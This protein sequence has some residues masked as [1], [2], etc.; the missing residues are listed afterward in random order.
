MKI[1]LKVPKY[2][3]KIQEKLLEN[4][5]ECYFVGGCIRDTLLGLKVND[6]DISTN[7]DTITLK[8]LFSKYNIVNNNGEKHNT[9]TLH[10]KGDNV[11]ITTFK[12]NDEE[13]PTIE[14]DLK[15]RDLTINALAYSNEIID[16]TG[17]ID[18]I[19][20]KIIRANA[21]ELRIKEDP[22]RIL[23]VLRFTSKLG[24]EIEK[25]TNDAILKYK[26]LLKNVSAERIKH[27]LEEILEGKDVY[28]ILEKYY[29]IIFVI[30]PELKCSYKFNQ[31][32][33]YHENTLYE[34]IINVC[35][36]IKIN[37][38]LEEFALLRMAALLH[39]IGKPNCFSID[40]NGVGHFYGHPEESAIIATNILKRLKFSNSEI[41]K[42][43]YLIK[44]HDST[45]NL[46]NKSI[47]KNFSHTPNQKE[48]LFYM[49]LELINADKL[50][51]TKYEL[52]DIEKVKNIINEIKEEKQCL[53]LSDL[54]VNG[55]DIIKLGY[56]GKKIGEVLDYLLDLVIDDKIKNERDSLMAMALNY[57]TLNDKKDN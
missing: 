4:G 16:I 41:S 17:G 26:D 52:I 35:R 34:H 37:N 10:I 42:I 8:K 39:D 54:K 50:D 29:D 56:K 40:V 7:C 23:R 2:I 21:P 45:I 28:K 49:L 30:I 32:N 31:N 19:N 14:V 13:T 27:E 38:N 9:I 44:F 51:H 18:D 24:F 57:R 20:N 3:K 12:H 33:P 53:K 43:V 55:Y 22:L 46:T 36:N 47:I 11:E 25:K 1:E 15:H 5:Y 6:Y 48:E